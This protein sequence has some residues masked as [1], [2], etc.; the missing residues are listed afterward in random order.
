MEKEVGE[1]IHEREKLQQEIADLRKENNS[2]IESSLSLESQNCKIKKEIKMTQKLLQEMKEE[3][4]IFQSERQQLISTLDRKNEQILR[5]EQELKYS[6]K[7]LHENISSKCEALAKLDASSSKSNSSAVD[8]ILQQE[9]SLLKSQIQSLKLTVDRNFH[10]LMACRNENSLKIMN[11]ENKLAGKMEEIRSSKLLNVQLE[12]M[13][14]ELQI[15]LDD[16]INKVNSDSELNKKIIEHYERELVSQKKVVELHKESQKEGEIQINRLTSTVKELQNLIHEISED[17]GNLETRFKENETKYQTDLQD[18]EGTIQRLNDEI[19]NANYLLKYSKDDSF[20]YSTHP[21]PNKV[22]SLRLTELYLDYTKVSDELVS[23]KKENEKLQANLQTILTEIEAKAPELQRQAY[24]YQLLSE[25]NAK[26]KEQLKKMNI[27]INE[28]QKENE[29]SVAKI[30]FLL[31]ENMKLKTQKGDLSRQVCNL[32]QEVERSRSF[33]NLYEIATD[34]SASEVISKK[35]S[36]VQ[37][38]IK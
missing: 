5:M 35:V 19:V 29:K 25:E 30:S 18:K 1:L 13:N 16:M 10:D 38:L 12:K 6:E 2:V 28:T 9:N 33:D 20:D 36:H 14:N 37:F 31:R 15:K 3:N 7:I 27:E 24:E 21:R 17:Y 8:D 11:L 34:M 23:Q 4:Q 26:L 32:L 22:P